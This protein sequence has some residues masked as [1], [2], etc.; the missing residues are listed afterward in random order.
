MW[1]K[2]CFPQ[3]KGG[4]GFRRLEEFNLALLAKQ[5][6]RLM[7]YP[8]SLVARVLRGMYFC[9]SSP[10]LVKPSYLPSYGWRN[11]LAARPLLL[12]SLR[13]NIGSGFDTRVWSDPWI[14]T[15]LE[16]PMTS[17]LTSIDSNLYVIADRPN[18]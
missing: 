2:F 13:K 9:Y 7:K 16:C 3:S 14:P 4:L 6:W 17:K 12:S 18:H 15:I 11:K 1:D 8:N 5:L 10:L